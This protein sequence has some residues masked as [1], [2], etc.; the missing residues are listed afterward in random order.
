[1]QH[2]ALNSQINILES[3]DLIRIAQVEPDLEYLFRHAL[4][5]DAAYD[6]LLRTD[7]KRL[8]LHVG[9][10]LESLY[11]DRLDELA[12]V[13]G[14]HFF[15][16]G[17]LDRALR[18]FVRAGDL[19]MAKYANTEA[20][21]H[22]SRAIEIAQTLQ[23]YE[24]LKTLYL[25]RGRALELNSQHD[26]ALAS[27]QEMETLAKTIGD[28]S[29]ELAALTEII[30]TYSIYSIVY[31]PKAAELL[32]EPTLALAQALGDRPAEA[33]ILWCT[34]LLYRDQ[35]DKAV[36]PGE[37][38]LAIARELNLK[39][40]LAYILHDLNFIYFGLGQTERRIAVSSESR[41]LWRELGNLPMLVDNLATSTF[42]SSFHGDFDEAIS[43]STE[44]YQLSKSIDN[45]WGQAYSLFTVDLVYIERGDLGE[46]FKIIGQS[47]PLSQKAGFIPGQLE[48]TLNMAT[49][50]MIVGQYDKARDCLE[51]SQQVSASYDTGWN[52]GPWA[53]F[54]EL[55]VLKGDLA[56]AE[57]M[58]KQGNTVLDRP[59]PNN[60]NVMYVS[61]VE[62][63]LALEK[64]EYDRALAITDNGLLVLYR[65]SIN[66]FIYQVLYLRA[67]ALVGLGRQQEAYEALLEAR[68][69]GEKLTGRR[70]LWRILA[71]L[72]QLESDRGNRAEALR[73]WQQACE[74]I[75]YIADHTGSDEY[76]ASFL[77]LPDVR[78]VLDNRDLGQ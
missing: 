67:L 78:R 36:G 46:A 14:A 55:S 34:V 21:M 70:F 8:H 64:L 22:Y 44:A 75:R 25:R 26:Q 45:L 52:M 9:E 7:R 13:L 16:A 10:T 66:I 5:Q 77:A 62:T 57:A 47:L 63:L 32:I 61:R 37:R 2:M 43:A 50:F 30:K 12:P 68:S 59:N 1:M 27:Y 65:L 28:R 60:P 4:V 33:K 51:Q 53:G 41:Q 48:T 20:T 29:L 19:A 40:Q 71:L 15:E 42:M 76:R 3:A 31:N 74:I 73:L 39:E 6:S 56:Q 58:L 17:D 35:P 54:A 18:Y 49:A 23:D 72:S 69:A 24:P 38:G 11:P